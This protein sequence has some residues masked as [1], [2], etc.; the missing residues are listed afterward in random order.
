MGGVSLSCFGSRP[1]KAHLLGLAI[2]GRG[3]ELGNLDLDLLVDASLKLGTIAED[4][5]NLEPDKHGSQE[6]GLEE[7]VKQTGGATLKGAVADEL[8]NPGQNVDANGDL[9]GLLGVLQAHVARKSRAADAKGGKD[10]AGNR[11]KQQVK[12]RIGE[13]NNCAKIEIQ[14]GH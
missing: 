9:K 1:H 6:Q 13:S 2:L 3:C 5:E 4:K 14:V 12:R 7:S 8:R 10:E 11:L